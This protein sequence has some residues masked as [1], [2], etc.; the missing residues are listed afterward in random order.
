V[1]IELADGRVMLN[2]RNQTRHERRRRLRAVCVSPDGARDWGPVRFDEA[3]VEPE[4]M[5][6]LVRLSLAPDGGKNRILFSNHDN[7]RSRERKNVT[8]KLSYNEG[9][10]WPVQKALER[11]RSGYSDLAVTPDGTILCSHERGS[12]GKDHMNAAH[13]CVARFNLE[14]LTDGR[15]RLP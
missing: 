12:F 5:A 13:L 9:E 10:T 2:M 14:W 8:I 15:D 4:C 3:L 7:A 6:N 11:G 1:A